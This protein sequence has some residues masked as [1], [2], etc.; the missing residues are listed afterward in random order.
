VRLYAVE[1]EGIHYFVYGY[2]V[3]AKGGLGKWKRSDLKVS[4][5]A[6][7]LTQFNCFIGE[8][9]IKKLQQATE[10]GNITITIGTRQ[11][12]LTSSRLLGRP[13]VIAIPHEALSGDRPRSFSDSMA[14]ME[15][16]WELD[17]I[18][19][20]D[21][22]FPQPNFNYETYQQAS[23]QLLEKLELETGVNFTNEDTARFGNFEVFR[24]LSGDF[25][26][27]DGL[28]CQ[29]KIRGTDGKERF[30]LLVWL[31]PPIGNA[32]DLVV[33]CRLYNGGGLAIETCILN[34]I[35]PYH[36][37]DKLEFIPQE[38]FSRFEVS[39]WSN[40]RLVG[41]KAFSIVR[42]IACNMHVDGATR[43]IKTKWSEGFPPELQER[44]TKIPSS[45]SQSLTIASRNQDPWR[46]VG[47]VAQKID[48]TGLLKH[49]DGQF[50]GIGKEAEIE[51][52]E[53]LSGLIL[54]PKVN[55]VVI[56]DPFFDEIGVHSLLLKIRQA[57]EV[58]VLVSHTTSSGGKDKLSI[59][60]ERLREELPRDITVINIETSEGASQQFHDRYI[61]I[62]MNEQNRTELQ[63]WMLSNSFSSMAKK[64]PLIVVKLPRHVASNVA[65]YIRNLEQGNPA[66]KHHAIRRILWSQNLSS[67]TRLPPKPA[68]VGFQG[69]EILLTL[70]VSDQGLLTDWHVP[71]EAL[72]TVI[73]TV[74][75]ALS[76]EPSRRTELLWIIARWHY[77]GGPEPSEY[78]F[79][80][81]ELEWLSDAFRKLLVSNTG[82]S[83]R[84]EIEVLQ[85]HTQLPEALG[86]IWYW[87]NQ[88]PFE[89]RLNTDPALYF[90]ANALWES[91]PQ[92]IAAILDETKNSSLFGW[93]CMEGSDASVEQ[94]QH[95]LMAKSGAIKAL[96]IVL[97][98]EGCEHLAQTSEGNTTE[99]LKAKL[100]ESTLPR[101]E[102]WLTLIFL[103]ARLS[104][105]R[106][107]S[108]QPFIKSIEIWPDAQLSKEE[109]K[110][111]TSLIDRA[112]PN[113]AIKLVSMLAD[114]CPRMDD[115]KMLYQ[116]CIDQILS[117]LPI[118]N[119][120]KPQQGIRI[121]CDPET[122]LA[123]AH[124]VWEVYANN[125]AEWFCSEILNKLKLSEAQEPLLRTR[126]YSRWSD[127][128]DSV[129]LALWFGRAI[130]DQAPS[131]QQN[132]DFAIKTTPIMAKILIDL[133]PEVWRVYVH[134]HDQLWYIMAFIGWSAEYC[135]EEGTNLI[136]RLVTADEVPGLW[137]LWLIVQSPKLLLKYS[138]VAESLARQ[139]C[140]GELQGYRNALDNW[141][142]SIF[143]ALANLNAQFPEDVRLK[144]LSHTIQNNI[145]CWQSRFGK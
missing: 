39:V 1:R 79:Q 82:Q 131:L 3:S 135:S 30:S 64:Y 108:I 67:I 110:R 140:A 125:S 47:L 103:E 117:Q 4:G 19:L 121:W 40:N 54:Q 70:L 90:F 92:A 32:K 134:K 88:M 34:E 8:Q 99:L 138:T 50:F 37:S 81:S 16:H 10:S 65:T 15:S 115:R 71:P 106:T 38:P 126:D 116:W 109:L 31:E 132:G 13:R 24:H 127:A 62:E 85:D 42:S 9:E 124:T 22:V 94:S 122:I 114:A 21:R 36:H 51:S 102:V 61:L 98:R 11:Y 6:W 23:Q 57:K 112:S 89:M 44:A 139:P 69:S 133:G 66:G 128:V 43:H 25:R 105:R 119:S 144:D 100:L 29:S 93:L 80:T 120:P 46:D 33:G 97:L 96:G 77:H 58:V 91:Y 86:S 95:L 53:Y 49:S 87:V 18:A 123:S 52:V 48:P 107:S 72:K 145:S 73:K 74:K 45:F 111:L 60:C 101:N 143:N 118:K 27:P 14:E 17:K 141:C 75:K 104:D 137:R 129:V 35:R 26:I 63:V 68:S 28:C 130:S 59:E 78:A 76:N 83:G 136:K 55:R 142:D 7:K 2:A 5:S 56:I 20:V 84:F 113:R 12:S 41:Y